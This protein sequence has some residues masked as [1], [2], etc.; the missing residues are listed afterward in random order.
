MQALTLSALF[1]SVFVGRWIFWLVH[2]LDMVTSIF[3]SMLPATPAGYIATSAAAAVAVAAVRR[4][5]PSGELIYD[6]RCRRV[7]SLLPQLPALRRGYSPPPLIPWSLAQSALA[8]HF[9]PP[10]EV[11][12]HKFERESLLMPPI[13]GPPTTRCCP[14]AVPKGTISIDWLNTGAFLLGGQVAP[15]CVLV[16]GLTGSSESAYVRRAALALSNAG[17]RVACFNPRGRAGNE[18]RTPFFY[19]AGFTPDLRRALAHIRRIYPDAPLTA[20]GFSLGANYLAK[21]VGEEG[22]RCELSCAAVFACPLDLPLMSDNLSGGSFFSRALDRYALVPSVK[23][24]RAA[25]SLLAGL[26][27]SFR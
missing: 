26:C 1:V 13:I 12:E 4:C 11:V 21:Y 19:S 24:V 18:L 9:E 8:D 6:E 22:D 25:L 2:N 14:T 5:L 16:P 23:R 10:A 27:P 7:Q 17:V 20:A 3:A 15:I